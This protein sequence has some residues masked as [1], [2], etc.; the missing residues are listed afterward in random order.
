MTATDA[1][2]AS[3]QGTAG[4][5]E[6]LKVTGLNVWYG[7]AQAVFDVGISVRDGEVVGLLGRNGAGKSSTMLG[8]IGSGVRRG[9]TVE[10]A[11][12][13]VTGYP[14]HR[15]AR[16]GI[17]WVPD[18]RKM[19]PTLT[20]AENFGVA[21][22]VAKRDSRLSDDDLVDIFPLLKPIL[23]RQAGVLSGGEQ[24]V[25]SIARAMVARPK[26]LLVDEPTEGL[27]PVI[28]EALIETFKRMQ[29]ELGQS[30]LLAEANQSVV[31]EV[32]S[33]VV[34]LA[35]GREVYAADTE[36]FAANTEVQDRYL[37][38]ATE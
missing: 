22:A 16:A 24:Q 3:E 35:T 13:D 11:G 38:I 26:V 28:V 23:Q 33:R 20:V 8:I 37:S 14:V 15:I 2:G 1:Q 27:A 12:R 5:E 32:A 21:R 25:V 36:T 30:M 19:F 31:G 7:S 18:D 10:F 17:A 9:G 4:G 29:S 6:L 34:V